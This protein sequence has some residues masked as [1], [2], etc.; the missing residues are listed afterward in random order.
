[1][2]KQHTKHI[3]KQSQVGDRILE[4]SMISNA[5]IYNFKENRE[6]IRGYSTW[7]MQIFFELPNNP[8]MVKGLLFIRERIDDNSVS[9]MDIEEF[10]WGHYV[11][12]E[13]VEK[14]K[15][16]LL[17]INYDENYQDIVILLLTYK[18]Y[19]ELTSLE[20]DRSWDFGDLELIVFMLKYK[21][22]NFPSSPLVLYPDTRKTEFSYSASNLMHGLILKFSET[23]EF[24]SY[25]QLRTMMREEY[26]EVSKLVGILQGPDRGKTVEAY[27]RNVV[28]ILFLSFRNCGI[29]QNEKLFVV[30]ELISLI[31]AYSSHF[32][33]EKYSNL[34]DFYYK[35]LRSYVQD[36]RKVHFEETE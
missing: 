29:K 1:M 34:S 4:H 18:Y 14:V 22:D 7:R 23:L 21:P 24:K 17:S 11:E 13:F 32:N 19:L 27:R 12:M 35:R 9:D 33:D 36:I 26:S 20:V 31:D 30:G 2:K 16:L 3:R 25:I 5:T 6:C 8:E 15:N 10:R 28:R